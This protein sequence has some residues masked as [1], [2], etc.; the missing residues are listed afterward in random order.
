MKKIKRIRKRGFI[1]YTTIVVVYQIKTDDY[2]YI[3]SVKKGYLLLNDNGTPRK[4]DSS[5]T[6]SGRYKNPWKALLEGAKLLSSCYVY[7]GGKH[8]PKNTQTNAI[9][10]YYA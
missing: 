9:K 8:S 3:I 10:I 5:Y 6:S 2:R 7:K 4:Y 1:P